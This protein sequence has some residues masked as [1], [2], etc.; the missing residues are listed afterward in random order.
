VIK[1]VAADVQKLMAALPQ[2][3]FRFAEDGRFTILLSM[4]FGKD[5]LGELRARL[6]DVN[7]LRTF[8]TTLQRRQ[9]RLGS[10]PLQRV[11]FEYGP[12]SHAAAVS[13]SSEKEFTIE[14]S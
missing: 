9:M 11:Q 8:T 4:P 13:F 7:Y 5:I 14:C 6:R 10:S 12:S 1:A 2:N 3:S